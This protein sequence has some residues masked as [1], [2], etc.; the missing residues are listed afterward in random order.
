MITLY[1][2]AAMEIELN[3]LYDVDD[4][5]DTLQDNEFVFTGTRNDLRMMVHTAGLNVTTEIVRWKKDTCKSLYTDY[6]V[7]VV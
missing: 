4:L 6:V 1:E 2:D 7:T 5:R 3:T